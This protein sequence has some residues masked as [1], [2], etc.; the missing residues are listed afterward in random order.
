MDRSPRDHVLGV[1]GQR[2]PD[3]ENQSARPCVHQAGQKL[4]SFD[5]VGQVRFS[6]RSTEFHAWMIVVRLLC[7]AWDAII[8][9]NG[10]R[11][12]SVLV[13]KAGAN[14]SGVDTDRHGS[15]RT[16]ALRFSHRLSTNWADWFVIFQ[17]ALQAIPVE[18]VT[19]RKSDNRFFLRIVGVA[20][21]TIDN[22]KSI[23]SH[24]AQTNGAIPQLFCACIHN[25][26]A[27]KDPFALI[28]QRIGSQIM[29]N[30]DSARGVGAK[31]S[32]K[33]RTHDRIP[34]RMK[35]MKRCL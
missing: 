33:R 32:A 23:L 29:T 5:I 18:T 34:S 27:G 12:C 1:R 25:L 7:P 13:S 26:Q 2:C 35:T 22:S 3:I 16:S 14:V 28:R 21:A 10:L 15:R 11:W 6:R 4:V 9:H 20:A 24:F 31:V 19:A 17:R 8:D 30:R